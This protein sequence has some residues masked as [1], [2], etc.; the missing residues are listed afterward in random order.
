MH[1]ARV[2]WTGD[3]QFVR[4]R[5]KS[6]QGNSTFSLICGANERDHRKTFIVEQFRYK[7]LKLQSLL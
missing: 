2:S 3:P 7:V 6:R 4:A 1:V 5:A